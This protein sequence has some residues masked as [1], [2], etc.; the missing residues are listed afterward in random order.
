[1]GKP[2]SISTGIDVSK[3]IQSASKSPTKPTN[4][5]VVHNQSAQAAVGTADAA[6]AVAPP[7]VRA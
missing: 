3:S 1:L 6:K 7:P 5:S 4:Y 2:A